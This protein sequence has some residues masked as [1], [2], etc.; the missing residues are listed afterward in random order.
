MSCKSFA[1]KAT[2]TLFSSSKLVTHPS[3][4]QAAV[5]RREKWLFVVCR[6]LELLKSY[7]FFSINTKEKKVKNTLHHQHEAQWKKTSK[8]SLE[9]QK[10]EKDWRHLG[11]IKQTDWSAPDKML[12]TLMSPFLTFG[13][14]L[15]AWYLKAITIV[16]TMKKLARFSLDT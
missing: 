1:H 10:W 5:E 13:S 14:T 7:S 6:T 3:F 11:Q 2:L 9:Q 8:L 4:C 16:C 15:T 12:L